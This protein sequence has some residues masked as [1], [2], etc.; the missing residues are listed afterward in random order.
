MKTFE[1]TIESVEA[2]EAILND[3][4][5]VFGLAFPVCKYMLE[6]NIDDFLVMELTIEE[7]DINGKSPKFKVE[8]C[9]EGIPKFLQLYLQYLIDTEQYEK[10][11][12]VITLIE[13]TK[14][15]EETKLWKS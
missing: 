10:C 5:F 12:E 1:K 11:K 14:V 4:E 6:N 13:E 8:L 3:R 15:I 9:R 2:G 7:Q